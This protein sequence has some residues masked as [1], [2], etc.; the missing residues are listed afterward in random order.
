MVGFRFEC[1]NRTQSAQRPIRPTARPGMTIDSEFSPSANPSYPPLRDCWY[2]AGPTASGKTGVGL[3]LAERIDGEIISLDSMAVYRGMD[4]G[5]AKPTLDERR[6]VPH[7]MI[8]VVS[9]DQEFSLSQFMEASHQAVR[10]ITNRKRTAVFV[11]GTPL[12][13]KSLL[14]G[15]VAGPPADWEFRQQIEAELEE[16]GIAAL[17]QRL[18]QVDPLAAAKL[19]PNDKRRIIRALEFYKATGKPISHEQV[20]FDDTPA[21]GCHVFVLSWSREELRA[22]IEVRVDR[23]F[24]QGMVDEVRGLL[25]KHGQFSRTALQAVGYR[26]VIEF[27]KDQRSL[28]ETVELVKI[29]TRQFARRQLTWFRSLEECRWFPLETEQKQ[30]DVAEN[31][32]DL[33]DE[34]A[35]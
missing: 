4:V 27:L 25:A 30:S 14:R 26:E 10:E 22:R 8:D 35:R 19:H 3:E 16:V 7:H 6:R 20:H 18:Q 2:L 23:M 34:Q 32:V 1:D 12:Y 15:V 31:I 13:L 28:D 17:H 11:G 9:P 29:R 24:S 21:G 5:T 33:V